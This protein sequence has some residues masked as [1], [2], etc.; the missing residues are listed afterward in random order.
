MRHLTAALKASTPCLV[1]HTLL[2][3]PRRRLNPRLET[4]DV[5]RRERDHQTNGM[6]LVVEESTAL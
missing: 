5:P 3:E 4:V 6:G 1:L 2:R